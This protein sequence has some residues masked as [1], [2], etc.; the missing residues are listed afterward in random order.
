MVDDKV[1]S[2]VSEVHLLYLVIEL[3]PLKDLKGVSVD[4][5]DLVGF[6][7]SMTTLDT[8]LYRG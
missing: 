6:D 3:A 8:A 1:K 2:D 5:K 7:L 4:E